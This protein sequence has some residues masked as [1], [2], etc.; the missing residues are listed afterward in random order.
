MRVSLRNL[1]FC[2]NSENR[3]QRNLNRNPSRVPEWSCNSIEISLCCCPDDS[4][5]EKRCILVSYLLSKEQ[6]LLSTY[7]HIHE[8]TTAEAVKPVPTLRFATMNLN[9][10]FNNG[11]YCKYFSRFAHIS[12]WSDF[13]LRYR[14]RNRLTST[15]PRPKARPIPTTTPYPAPCESGTRFSDSIFFA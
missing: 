7:A 6:Q 14:S 3:H 10:D 4:S 12:V 8:D 1:D 2:M 13:S 9:Q 15:M 5:S 11:L